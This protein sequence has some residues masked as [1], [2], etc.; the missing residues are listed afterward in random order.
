M[1]HGEGWWNRKLDGNRCLVYGLKR[2]RKTGKLDGDG[3]L[4]IKFKIWL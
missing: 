4:V 2:K 1:K 3:K